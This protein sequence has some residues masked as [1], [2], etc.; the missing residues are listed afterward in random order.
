MISRHA[1]HVPFRALY[2]LHRMVS[3]KPSYLR[4][5]HTQSYWCVQ[6]VAL[7]IYDAITP[8]HIGACRAWHSRVALAKDV[9]LH[10][11]HAHSQLR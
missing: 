7:H 6:D 5:Y 2:W 3:L 1:S 9:G 4:R 8:T 10:A 11:A